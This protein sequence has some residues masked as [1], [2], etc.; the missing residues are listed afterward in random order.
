MKKHFKLNH[1]LI[2]RILFP[3]SFTV[4]TLNFISCEK[5]YTYIPPPPDTTVPVS[6]SKDI[7]PIFSANCNASSCHLNNA[8]SPDLT[9]VPTA[10]AQMWVNDNG[11]VL[12]DTSNA[13]ANAALSKLYKRMTATTNPMPPSGKLSTDKTDLVLTWI[14]QGAKNN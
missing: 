6:F 9:D 3:I 8:N 2:K 13:G 1:A 5:D 14:K 7:F 11:N 12:V 10:Y 4:I